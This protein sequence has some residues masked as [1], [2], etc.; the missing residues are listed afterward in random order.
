MYEV[1]FY[2]TKNI[3]QVMYNIH[4]LHLIFLMLFL[5]RCDDAA[6]F[7]SNLLLCQKQTVDEIQSF[8]LVFV[9]SSP[10]N[11]ISKPAKTLLFATSLK[12]LLRG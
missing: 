8:V 12:N 10:K 1:L 2:L 9:L 5:F 6:K 4:H 7:C 11:Q 3:L